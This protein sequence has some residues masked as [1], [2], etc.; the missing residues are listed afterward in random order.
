MSES[1]KPSGLRRALF[2]RPI[3]KL[4]LTFLFMVIVSTLAR[5]TSMPLLRFLVAAVISSAVVYAIV[6]A[7]H[8]VS[9][10]LIRKPLDRLFSARD[11]FSLLLSY[12][13]FIVGIL[14]VISVIFMVVEDLHLGYLTYDPTEKLSRDM[15]DNKDPNLSQDY[16]YFSAITFF[17][18]GY[19]DVCP[20]GFCKTL[21][22]ATAFA[23]NVVTVVLMAIVVSLYL[24]RR[25]KAPDQASS[26]QS[27]GNARG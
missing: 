16:L 6:L 11:L 3:L 20:M 8:I 18:V 10:Y 12:V 26:S 7:G 13:M 2:D 19:G 14:L 15:I 9:L 5:Y 24:N 21:A 23:G 17:S 27:E 22:M 25:T 1:N 4:F